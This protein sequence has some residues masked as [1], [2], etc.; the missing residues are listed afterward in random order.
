MMPV[1]DVLALLSLSVPVLAGGFCDH[2]SA[3]EGYSSTCHNRR[4]LSSAVLILRRIVITLFL[5]YTAPELFV[6]LALAVAKR[7]FKH[8]YITAATPLPG[9]FIF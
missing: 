9:A 6:P 5:L 1:D 7:R 8:G 4:H 2:D 3:F